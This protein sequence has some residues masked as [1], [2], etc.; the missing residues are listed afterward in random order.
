[1]V[2][3]K[4]RFDFACLKLAWSIEPSKSNLIP[5]FS[6]Q[7]ASTHF[8][9]F[10]LFRFATSF[11]YDK[12]SDE[13]SIAITIPFSERWFDQTILLSDIQLPISTMDDF[14]FK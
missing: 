1:M 9:F 7:T 6:A 13:G 3:T 11:P 2:E 10:T 5:D 8:I 14:E 4:Y 12:F